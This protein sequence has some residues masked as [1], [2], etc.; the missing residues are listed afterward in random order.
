MATLWVCRSE[1]FRFI[2]M[3]SETAVM[4]R[5]ESPLAFTIQEPHTDAQMMRLGLDRMLGA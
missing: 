2:K 5:L 1:M 3:M 4:S